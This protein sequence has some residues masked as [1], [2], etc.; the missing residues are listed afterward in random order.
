MARRCEN[1]ILMGLKLPRTTGA[2]IGEVQITG[3]IHACYNCLPDT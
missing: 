3:R 1:G 2:G